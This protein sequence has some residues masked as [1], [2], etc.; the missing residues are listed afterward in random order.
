MGDSFDWDHGLP[1]DYLIDYKH[2]IATLQAE[3]PQLVMV[4]SN[5]HLVGGAPT[6]N[7]PADEEKYS[8]NPKSISPTIWDHVL[9]HAEQWRPDFDI[10]V[11]ANILSKTNI[12]PS[13]AVPIR[14]DLIDTAFAWPP[15]SDG[16]DFAHN[17]GRIIRFPP[18][19]EDISSRALF[20][21]YNKIGINDRPFS[22]SQGA[23]LGAHLRTEGDA[24]VLGWQ[25]YETQCMKIREE[26]QRHN[27]S[28]L[29][30]ASGNQSQVELLHTDLSDLRIPINSTHNSTVQI[31]Q[32][33]DLFDYTDKEFISHLTWDQLGLVDMNILFRSS[34]FIGVSESSFSWAI[35]LERHDWSQQN[36][37]SS[38]HLTFQDEFSTLNGYPG[39]MPLIP[40]TMWL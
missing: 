14:V 4:E 21:L 16:N 6:L 23:F 15:A 2:F 25:S 31:Y 5:D 11:E 13:E 27:L 36:P 12:T 20:N 32:K 19:I 35:A 18:R 37:Y 1:L 39:A 22:I 26:L 34:K 3:C 38:P 28:N 10:W 29:Y 8:V 17:F 9:L 33:W 30:V 24:Q 40:A 7:V